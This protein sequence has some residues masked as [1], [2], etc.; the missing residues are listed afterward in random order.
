MRKLIVPFLASLALG[1]APAA[2]VVTAPVNAAANVATAT[3]GAAAGVAT[4][5]TG[6]AAG[7]ATGTVGT[8]A[9]VA[10]APA[11][12]VAGAN[13]AG[14]VATTT[15]RQ[16]VGGRCRDDAAR[17]CPGVTSGVGKCLAQHRSEVSESCAAI[18]NSLAKFPN[19]LSD[20]ERL[21]PNITASGSGF[22]ACMRTRQNDL[23][24]ECRQQMHKVR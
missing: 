1:C 7:V 9:N 20:A 6:A 21:C 10:T 2:K 15:G 24:E 8:A 18:L 22:M 13:G 5:A 11:A 14:S 12:A 16:A 19:C 23:S 17:L 4:T 3:T